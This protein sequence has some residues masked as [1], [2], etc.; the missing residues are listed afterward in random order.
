M[1]DD[2]RADVVSRQYARWTYPQPIQDL[3]EWLT[4]HCEGL[5]PSLSYGLAKSAAA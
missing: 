4:G 1:N 2:P 5:D 3:D